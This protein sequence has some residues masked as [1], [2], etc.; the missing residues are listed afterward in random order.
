[1]I[2]P[3]AHAPPAAKPS[4][5]GPADHWEDLIIDACFRYF[6]GDLQP[7]KQADVERAMQQWLG[8][9]ELD[10]AESTIRERAKKVW[11]AIERDREADK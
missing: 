10:P 5:R 7:K 11:L 4:R 6:R 8:E 2:P 1:M 3:A 9:H